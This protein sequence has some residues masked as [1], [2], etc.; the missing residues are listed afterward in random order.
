MCIKINA[1]HTS[2][3]DIRHAY[4]QKSHFYIIHLGWNYYIY[5]LI[6]SRVR[7]RKYKKCN[8]VSQEHWPCALNQGKF[9]AASPSAPWGTFTIFLTK[10]RMIS[11]FTEKKWFFNRTVP[12]TFQD[13]LSETGMWQSP[14]FETN[15]FKSKGFFTFLT[16]STSIIKEQVEHF[17]LLQPSNWCSLLIG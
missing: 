9:W 15:S 3:C 12:H 10:G 16:A 13:F 17:L 1:F 14:N 11:S 7:W 8:P 5:M 4:S 6:Q 2:S